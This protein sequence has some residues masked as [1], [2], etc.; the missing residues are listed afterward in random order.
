MIHTVKIDESTMN[1]KKLMR[2]VRRYKKG[3]TI[4][5]SFVIPEG[6]MTGEEFRKKV[7]EG[8]KN[9]LKANGYL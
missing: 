2:E 6:Y 4:E 1:G 5:N 9:R 3:V 7:K 8:L